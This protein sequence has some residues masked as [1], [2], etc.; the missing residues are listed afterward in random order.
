MEN[1]VNFELKNKEQKKKEFEL[2]YGLVFVDVQ[3]R[4]ND[5]MEK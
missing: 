3:D 4:M 1:Y 5:F 2:G